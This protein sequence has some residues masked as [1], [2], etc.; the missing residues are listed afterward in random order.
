M[1]FLCLLFLQ[2]THETV[3]STHTLHDCLHL[4]LKLRVGSNQISCTLEI[5]RATFCTGREREHLRVTVLHV[6]RSLHLLL[7]FLIHRY[8]LTLKYLLL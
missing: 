6:S 1:L 4:F 8:Q 7:D 3:S 5:S 2:F